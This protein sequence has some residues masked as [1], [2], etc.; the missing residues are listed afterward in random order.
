MLGDTPRPLRRLNVRAIGLEIWAD[1]GRVSD[2]PAMATE[3]L[4]GRLAQLS[5]RPRG[6]LARP[7]PS[8]SLSFVPLSL[9]QGD[10][11]RGGM[12]PPWKLEKTPELVVLLTIASSVMS[13]RF[14]A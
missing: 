1:L 8:D 12:H 14:V 11:E 6:L 4:A 13:Q 9:G 3:Q 2:T 7:S 5:S 10:L